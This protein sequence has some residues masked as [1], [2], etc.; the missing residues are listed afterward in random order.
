MVRR[1]AADHVTRVIY[2]LPQGTWRDHFRRRPSSRQ[3]GDTDGVQ[4]TANRTNA[5]LNSDSCR[6]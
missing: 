2:D 1:T 4:W 6:R 3:D 5:W